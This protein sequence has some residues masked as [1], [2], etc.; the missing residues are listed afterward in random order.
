M[1]YIAIIAMLLGAALLIKKYHKP[2]DIEIEYPEVLRK[3]IKFGYFGCMDDQVAETVGHTSI[4]WECQF[5]GQQKAANNIAEAKLPTILDVSSQCMVRLTE[6]DGKPFVYTQAAAENLRNLFLY[7]RERDLLK[8]IYGLTPLDEP[9]TNALNEV[10]LQKAIWVIQQVCEEF[11]ELKNVKL[12]CI[13][14]AK[15]APYMLKEQFDI[16]LVDDY[17]ELSQIFVNG[18]YQELVH[19][20]RPDQKTGIMPGGGFDQDPAPFFNFAHAHPEVALIIA[21]VWFGP[22]QPADTWTGIRNN[23]RRAQYEEIG[24]QCIENLM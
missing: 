16:V 5:Q 18:T 19:G 22:M 11:Q 24:K 15:P 21:F 2:K 9:N 7:L 17:E 14:A 8:Y 1:I 23:S 4:L 20:L 3:G 6:R 13:Y 12:V 10:E